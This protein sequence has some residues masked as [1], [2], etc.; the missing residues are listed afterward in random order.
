VCQYWCAV[1][2]RGSSTSEDFNKNIDIGM[3]NR[4][5]KF[6][7]YLVISGKFYEDV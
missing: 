7:Y 5:K 1:L 2:V 3:L 4:D 6:Q